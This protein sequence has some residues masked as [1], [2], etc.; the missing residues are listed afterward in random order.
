VIRALPILLLLA[1]ILAPPAAAHGDGEA[2]GYRSAVTSV[3]PSIA[4]LSAL[5]LEGDDRLRL[6]NGSEQ[7]VEIEGYDGEPYLRF[8]ADGVFRNAKSSATYLNGERFGGVD[9]PEGVGPKAEPVWERVSR[10]RT[11][12][13]HDHRI[14]WMSTI[15][16][17]IVRDNPDEPHHVFDWKVPASADGKP[18]TIAGTLDYDPPPESALTWR[19]VV[20]PVALAFAGA[21]FWWR[22]KRPASA[23]RA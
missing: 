17:P 14:H 3:S 8:S 10:G 11:Y 6:S 22:R 23:R 2:R 15:D 20:P 9:V 18:L 16:P 5:V 21:V 13:W 1:A 12:E 4:G 7:T 19:W